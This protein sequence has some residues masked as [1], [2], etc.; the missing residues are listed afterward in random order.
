M[1]LFRLWIASIAILNISGWCAGAFPTIEG[2][3][4]LG[5]KIA[6]PQAAAGHT[7]VV[8]I[9]FTHASQ[10]Q[11]KAW[12]ARLTPEMS[13]YSL[14]VLQDV[15]RLVRGMAVAGIKSGVPQAQRERFLLVY[16]GE[17]ELKDAAGFD[18]PNDAYLV[19][20]DPD[21]IVRWHFHGE[22]TDGS[23]AELKSQVAEIQKKP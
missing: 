9:G 22:L 20:L 6:L 12:S 5:Q 8:V 4:L 3:N 21:G 10:S 2:E 7:T 16:R 13:T 18:R 1:Y 14:A 19:L 15:P 23:L 17:K 11:T